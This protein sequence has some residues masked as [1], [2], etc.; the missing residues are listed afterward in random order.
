MEKYR[1]KKPLFNPISNHVE[2]LLSEATVVKR[3]RNAV[4]KEKTIRNFAEKHNISVTQVSDTLRG[5]IRPSYA[6]CTAIGVIMCTAY[7]LK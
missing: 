4:E 7:R 1:Y 5:A 6:I 2:E 3:L